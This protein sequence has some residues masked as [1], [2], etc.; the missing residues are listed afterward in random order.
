VTDWRTDI[1]GITSAGMNSAVSKG[2]VLRDWTACRSELRKYI[3][4]NTILVGHSLNN[5]LKALRIKYTTIVDSSI[6]TSLAISSGQRRLGLVEICRELPKIEIR[7]V[8]TIHD[9]LEDTFAAREIVL[10]CLKHPIKLNEW[11]NKKKIAISPNAVKR[12]RNQ[13]KNTVYG[14]R[15]DHD[16]DYDERVEVLYWS[17]IAEELGWPHPDTGYDPWSD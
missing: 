4:S 7:V 13:R 16:D 3:D 6:L 12:H 2:T 17:D 10:W 5:D 8:G 1:T 11:A 15:P 14:S 9:S